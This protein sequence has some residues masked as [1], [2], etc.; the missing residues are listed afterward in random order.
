MAIDQ[1]AYTVADQERMARAGNYV[2]WQS[3]L[4]HRELGQRV[5][6]VGCGLGN[7]TGTLLDRE[8]VIAVDMEPRC[9]E[10]LRRRY[11]GRHNLHAFVCDVLSPGFRDLAR[12]RPDSCVCLNVLEHTA[13]DRAALAAMAS[14]VQPGGAI[15]LIVP[16]FQSLYGPI[17]RNLGHFRRYSRGALHS[18]AGRV[19]LR[20]RRAHYSNCIGFFGW[21][22]NA[23]LLKREAQSEHQIAVFDRYVVPVASAVEKLVP[24]PFGQSLVAVLERA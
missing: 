3:R 22:M 16:A 6:E 7:F 5:L 13:D 9:I 8:A 19:G 10:R 17:D 14:V 18:L 21:W 11:A 15:V 12:F 20:L 4:V 2:A 23:R 1:A 24:P